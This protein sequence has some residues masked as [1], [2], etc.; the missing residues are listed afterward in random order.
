MSK[1]IV[2]DL[3]DTL[4]HYTQFGAF[5]DAVTYYFKSEHIDVPFNQ[6]FFNH[7]IEL[8]PEIMRPDII[9]I[10]LYLKRKRIQ[11]KY[12]KLMIYTNNQGPRQW[13]LSLISYFET[14]VG[15]K[16]FDQ[17]IG[18]FKINNKK[19][20][21]CRTSHL[22]TTSDLIKCAKI[23]KQTQICFIDDTYFPNMCA[24]NVYYINIKPYI[25]HIPFP[26][27]IDRFIQH[28]RFDEAW[29]AANF[30]ST[31]LQYIHNMAKPTP[32]PTM[33]VDEHNIHTILSKQIINH[34]DIF[35]SKNE[36]DRVIRQHKT[37]TRKFRRKKHNKSMRLVY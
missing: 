34:L 7:C 29:N 28:K 2:L 8:Y 26:D 10:L 36:H 19:V 18:A 35:F 1:I 37:H 30:K 22:K 13:A 3:D 20:E 11:K 6:S 16:L 23:D 32:P 5:L 25:N 21:L 31:I 9:K 33:T 24:S 15:Y 17:L 14:M 27:M 4:G 12:G